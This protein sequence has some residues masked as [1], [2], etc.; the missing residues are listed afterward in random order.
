MHREG[1]T[2]YKRERDILYCIYYTHSALYIDIARLAMI[3]G[4]PQVPNSQIMVVMN[5][6]CTGPARAGAA[7]PGQMS[8]LYEAMPL[9]GWSACPDRLDW[10]GFGEMR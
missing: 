8:L 1:H 6:S 5:A 7:P 4:D 3:H 2:Y 9:V 10:I